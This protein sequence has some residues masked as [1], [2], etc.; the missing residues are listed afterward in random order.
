M[1]KT[2]DWSLLNEGVTIPVSAFTLLKT[3]DESILVHG[4]NKYI[5]KPSEKNNISFRTMTPPTS[6]SSVQI[7]IISST[8]TIQYSIER[9]SCLNSRMMRN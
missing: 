7:I 1:Q 8:K 9:N 3:W 6:L 5:M 4:A 2:V